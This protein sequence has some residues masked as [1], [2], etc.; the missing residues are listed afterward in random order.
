MD[1]LYVRYN[2]SYVKTKEQVAKVVQKAKKLCGVREDEQSDGEMRNDLEV[3]LYPTTQKTLQKKEKKELEK[4]IQDSEFGTFYIY[5]LDK[6]DF[7]SLQEHYEDET[8][9]LLDDNKGVSPDKKAI[10]LVRLLQKLYEKKEGIASDETYILEN[11][12]DGHLTS[13]E[14]LKRYLKDLHAAF[15]DKI[16]IEKKGHKYIYRL[17]TK[18]EVFEEVLQNVNVLDEIIHLLDFFDDADLQKLS[19]KTQD[20][21]KKTNHTVLYKTRPIEKLLPENKEM[22]DGF[23]DAIAQ[24]RYVDIYGYKVKLSLEGFEKE[25]YEGVVPLKIVFMENNWYLAGAFAKDN[26]EPIVRFWRINFIDDYKILE[27]KIEE[28]EYKKEFFDYLE[29]FES[30]FTRYKT[31]FKTATLKLSSQIAVQFENKKHFPKQREFTRFEDG[32]ATIKVGYTQ[33]MEILPTIRKWLPDIEVI[34][35]EDGAIEKKLVE[36]LEISLKKLKGAV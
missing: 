22:I 24:K 7:V 14:T 28:S 33:P 13:A 18:G 6:E 34:G 15:E 25:D 5:N 20:A 26:V 10:Y 30:P 29:E 1:I 3:I 35:S 11:I 12:T 27:K 31:P 17:V 9:E 36:D 4:I 8:F 23:K 32:S 2:K 16:V 21:I 19:K